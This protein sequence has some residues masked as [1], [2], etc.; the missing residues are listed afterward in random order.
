MGKLDKLGNFSHLRYS[1]M[2]LNCS[3]PIE[4]SCVTVS[5]YL[6]VWVHW[7]KY[8][9]VQWNS[10][11]CWSRCYHQS[12]GNQS[13]GALSQITWYWCFTENCLVL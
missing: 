9:D 1:E 5:L 11:D 7:A 4:E 8:C 10:S 12:T 13:K 6:N 3:F 2:M